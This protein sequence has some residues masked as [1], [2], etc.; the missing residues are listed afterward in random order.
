V[1]A[2]VGLVP[3]EAITDCY[4]HNEDAAPGSPSG[5]SRRNQRSGLIPHITL[6]TRRSRPDKPDGELT[7]ESIR[8]RWPLPLSIAGSAW[9]SQTVAVALN[10]GLRR[11]KVDGSR[12]QSC[13]RWFQVRDCFPI[14]EVFSCKFGNSKDICS[15]FELR[16]MS[17]SPSRRGRRHPSVDNLALRGDTST[18][19]D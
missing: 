1:T 5:S 4:P 18:A 14:E 19:C 10:Y 15:D 12:R 8:C 2:T 7:N 9:T 16:S 6:S 3:A 11:R 13:C 17:E